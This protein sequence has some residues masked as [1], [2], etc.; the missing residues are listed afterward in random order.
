MRI[1]FYVTDRRD[2]DFVDEVG[3]SQL[4][5]LCIDIGKKI[6]IWINIINI[7]L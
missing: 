4:G 5:E 3:V 2:I 1:I 7:K 6:Y